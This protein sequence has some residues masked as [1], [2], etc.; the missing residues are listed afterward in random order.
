MVRLESDFSL[1]ILIIVKKLY[2]VKRANEKVYVMT[3]TKKT[4]ENKRGT[5]FENIDSIEFEAFWDNGVD[6]KRNGPHT[7]VILN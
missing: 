7:K 3:K 6:I 2:F 5:K 4:A 1:E